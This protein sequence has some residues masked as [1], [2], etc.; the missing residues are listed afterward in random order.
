MLMPQVLP[1]ITLTCLVMQ[2]CA[3]VNE[4]VGFLAYN[5]LGGGVL[6]GKYLDSPAAPDLPTEAAMREQMRQPR[7]R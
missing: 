7:G 5:V 3:P 6:T 2:G 1:C 4:N